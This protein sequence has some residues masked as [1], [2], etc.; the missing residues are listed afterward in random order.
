M[1]TTI[2][3][4]KTKVGKFILNMLPLVADGTWII[5]NSDDIRNQRGECPICAVINYIQGD[6]QHTT[7]AYNASHDFFGGLSY[8]ETVDLEYIE[9]AADNFCLEGNLIAIRKYMEQ[10]LL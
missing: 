10:V 8:G 5:G 4:M 3:K 2:P 1:T 7:A 6:Y 9:Y